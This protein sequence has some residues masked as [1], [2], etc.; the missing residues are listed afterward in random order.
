MKEQYDAYGSVF[1][2]YDFDQKRCGDLVNLTQEERRSLE[3]RLYERNHSAQVRIVER[4]F[5][6]GIEEEDDMEYPFGTSRPQDYSDRLQSIYLAN[7]S[8]KAGKEKAHVLEFD[9]AP[10]EKKKTPR[11]LFTQSAVWLPEDTRGI[12]AKRLA[13]TSSGIAYPPPAGKSGF[14]FLF[15]DI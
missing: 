14:F 11:I 2:L 5:R 10:T 7:E 4:N 15:K 1:F 9:E 6:A 13:L 3:H 8:K 12:D